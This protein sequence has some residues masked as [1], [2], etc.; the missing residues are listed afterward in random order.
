MISWIESADNVAVQKKYRYTEASTCTY[1]KLSVRIV[2]GDQE[3]VNTWLHF[4]SVVAA[5][6]DMRLSPNFKDI[7]AVKST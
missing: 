5:S 1:Y 3:S 4:W 7:S 2:V 6:V